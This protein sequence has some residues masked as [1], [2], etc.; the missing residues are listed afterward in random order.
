M[1]PYHS[2]VTTHVP[3]F[4][5]GLCFITCKMRVLRYPPRRV[6]RTPILAEA[7]DSLHNRTALLSTA[8]KV[9]DP[10]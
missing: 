5:L 8:D 9:Q 10:Q 4:I 1:S 2:H 3:F 7:A 6:L